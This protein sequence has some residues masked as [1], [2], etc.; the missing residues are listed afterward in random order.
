MLL[1]QLVDLVLLY[2]FD[3]IFFLNVLLYMLLIIYVL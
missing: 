2:V 3:L 1:H